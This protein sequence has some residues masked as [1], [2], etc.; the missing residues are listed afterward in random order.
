MAYIR[1]SRK[2]AGKKKGPRLKDLAWDRAKGLGRKG[3]LKARQLK[4][5]GR[6]EAEKARIAAEK[7]KRNK[8]LPMYPTGDS[9]STKQGE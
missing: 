9:K 8:G 3:K 4:T 2:E 1:R 7:A 5:A 6:P